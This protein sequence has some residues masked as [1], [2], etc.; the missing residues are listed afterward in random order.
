M[1]Q[2]ILDRVLLYIIKREER[3]QDKKWEAF[4]AKMEKAFPGKVSRIPNKG[5]STCKGE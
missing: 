5:W 4:V 1:W 2:W 3:K